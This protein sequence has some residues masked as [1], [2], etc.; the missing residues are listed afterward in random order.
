MPDSV[1]PRTRQPSL[2][3]TVSQSLLKLMSTESVMPSNHLILCCPLHLLPLVFLSIRVLSSESAFRIRWPKYWSFSFSHQ[4]FQWVFRV[5]F[6]Y[7]ELVWSPCCPRDSQGSSPTPQF[8]RKIGHWK[9]SKLDVTVP[10]SISW[11]EALEAAPRLAGGRD[12]LRIVL[13]VL[14]NISSQEA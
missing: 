4:F 9:N 14:G 10:I 2:S 3:L 7:S 12:G 8:C 13:E 5:D 1:T 11:I 6:L